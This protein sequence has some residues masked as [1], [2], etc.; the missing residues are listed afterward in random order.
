MV[1]PRCT[2]RIDFHR[3]VTIIHKH[4]LAKLPETILTARLKTNI[5]IPSN[6]QHE[7]FLLTK[8]AAAFE[9]IK[10]LSN[11][12]SRQTTRHLVLLEDM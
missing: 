2:F 1:D 7:E 10:A 3:I 8:P 12:I 5:N 6:M 9:I 4:V 11:Q